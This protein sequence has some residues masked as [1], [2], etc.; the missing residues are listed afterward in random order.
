MLAIFNILAWKMYT[1]IKVGAGA[2]INFYSEPHKN[3]ASP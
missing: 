3:Y 1:D 2:R